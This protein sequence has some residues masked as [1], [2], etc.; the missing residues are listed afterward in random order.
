MA[1]ARDQ[2]TDDLVLHERRLQRA[3]G[4]RAA[5]AADAGLVGILGHVQQRRSARVSGAGPAGARGAPGEILSIEPVGT[6]IRI[7]RLG[8]P[9]NLQ[10]R[11]GQYLK[12]GLPGR[13]TRS[14]SIASA[15]HDPHLELCIELNPRGRLTPELFTLEPGSHLQL[16]D[17]AKGSFALDES[18][19][20]HLMVATGTGI[21]PLRS[22]VRDA[23]HRDLDAELTVLHG[24][25][26]GDELPYLGEMADL[27]AEDRRV[28]YL[29]TVSRPQDLRNRSWTGATG[30]VEAWALDLAAGLD[31]DDTRA[32]VC[33][34]PDMVA[35]VGAALS[36]TGL[37]VSTEA[38]D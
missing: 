17:A 15:P 18:V 31:A 26:F 37:A 3:A 19:G 34:H 12:V 9:P 4:A 32:Y 36:A 1:G 35:D 23:V 16:A 25:S 2:A 13:T 28:H 5:E 30:R 22:M 29:P 24:A 6:T 11:A 20:R 33:G 7:I 14:F 38:F 8:R 21:A 27:A 10:F